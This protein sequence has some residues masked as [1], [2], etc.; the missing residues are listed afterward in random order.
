MKEKNSYFSLTIIIVV[1]IIVVIFIVNILS[2]PDI[3]PNDYDEKIEVVSEN[4]TQIYVYSDT[5]DFEDRVSYINVINYENLVL[6]TS[7]DSVLIIDMFKYNQY[8]F[9]TEEQVEH[10]YNDLNFIIMIVNYQSSNSDKLRDIIDFRSL[11]S[12]LIYLTF[13][14]Q[15]IAVQGSFGSEIDSDEMM[16]YYIINHIANLLHERSLLE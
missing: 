1:I 10:L 8:P 2:V 15:N 4:R 11:E 3:T 7:T 12:D 9:I 13:D 6:N 16:G 14:A 5:I